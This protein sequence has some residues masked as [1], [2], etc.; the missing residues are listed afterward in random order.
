MVILPSSLKP[1]TPEQV[2]VR[3]LPEF[4]LRLGLTSVQLPGPA[5]FAAA[6]AGV[7]GATGVVCPANRS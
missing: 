7:V 2:G 6:G 1:Q 4:S 3:D 5:G